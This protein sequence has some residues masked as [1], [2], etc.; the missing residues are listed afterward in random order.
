MAHANGNWPEALGPSSVSSKEAAN[1][2]SDPPPPPSNWPLTL[3]NNAQ[4]LS[5]FTHF[6]LFPQFLVR[7]PS[8]PSPLFPLFPGPGEK[9]VN[10]KYYILAYL[11]YLSFLFSIA[12]NMF[13]I[14]VGM[15]KRGRGRYWHWH[16]P[17]P[18]KGALSWE[19]E[20]AS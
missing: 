5:N 2:T 18:S 7:P 1:P 19:W 11:L 3:L 6:S 17:G 8:P 16:L 4:P 10:G 9:P 12:K 15:I 20:H 13:V 14:E